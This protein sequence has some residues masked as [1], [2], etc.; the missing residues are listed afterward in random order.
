[1]WGQLLLYFLCSKYYFF[2]LFQTY[3]LYQMLA[4][5]YFQEKLPVSLSYVQASVLLCVGLQDQGISFIEVWLSPCL[6]NLHKQKISRRLGR[7]TC[8]FCIVFLHFY[9]TSKV[10]HLSTEHLATCI[11]AG[12]KSIKS[13]CYLIKITTLVDWWLSWLSWIC[14]KSASL[15][16]SW[17][18][19][20]QGQ[21]KLERQQLFSLFMKVMK[22]FY[23][24]L[25]GIASKEIESAMPRLKE[26]SC[27]SFWN[28]CRFGIFVLI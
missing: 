4:L 7:F 3:D 13:Q 20:W 8:L 9:L 6:L 19:I 27:E 10:T 16:L 1:M 22:K 28:F 12:E 14:K 11:V 2:R 18:V 23:K 25:N 24:Y 26:V 21:M 5:L 15:V 17:T